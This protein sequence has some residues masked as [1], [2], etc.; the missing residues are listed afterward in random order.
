MDSDHKIQSSKN[1]S[2]QFSNNQ[3]ILI[4]WNPGL[5]L[6][7]FRKKKQKFLFEIFLIVCR[8]KLFTDNPS[9]AAIIVA[10]QLKNQSESQ[11]ILTLLWFPV[12]WIATFGDIRQ[13]SWRRYG[14]VF[15]LPGIFLRNIFQIFRKYFLPLTKNLWQFLLKIKS[16]LL[17]QKVAT[18]FDFIFCLTNLQIFVIW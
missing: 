15:Y 9:F 12:F 13:M 10:T 5:K 18:A 14:L 17:L 11:D 6:K 3:C 2:N 16:D 7:T 8:L 1:S 4:W